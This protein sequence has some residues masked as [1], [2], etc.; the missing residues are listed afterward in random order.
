MSLPFS[1]IARIGAYTLKEHIKGGK[2]PLVLMLEPL[3]R[4]NLAC[5]GCGKIDYPDAI[6]NQRMSYE[7]CMEAIDECGAPA[8][9]IAGGEPLLH[10]DMA[11]I[12]KG[13]IAKKKFVILCT[14]ALLLKKKIDEYEP[15]PFFTWSIHLD[16]DKEMHDHAVDQQGTYDI[17]VEAIRLAKSKGFRVQVNCTVFDGADPARLAAYFDEMEALGVEITISPAMPMSAR[18][19]RSISSI[20][21]GPRNSSATCSRAGMAGKTGPSPTRLC[22]SISS[23]AT[24]PMNARPGRCRCARSSAGRSRAICSAKAM[25]RPSRS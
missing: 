20:A 6:L 23:R 19:I 4:C 22:S 9:S 12:V 10:K 5:P 18:P 3:F 16:G 15:S 7:Q 25:S 2:Y 11:R 21:S 14:N 1:Q 8:V 13:Y 24:R 17:A